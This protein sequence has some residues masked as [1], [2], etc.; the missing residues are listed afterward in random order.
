MDLQNQD[1]K[2]YEVKITQGVKTTTMTIE[3]NTTLSDIF[4]G[5]GNAWKSSA[6]EPSRPAAMKWCHQRWKV[7]KHK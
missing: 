1:G 4:P 5:D 2:K 6:S 3:G 7:T